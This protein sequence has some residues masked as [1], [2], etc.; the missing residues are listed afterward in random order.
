MTKSD[1]DGAEITLRGIM[2]TWPKIFGVML[3]L[4]IGAGT[5]VVWGGN[6][7]LSDRATQLQHLATLD[8]YVHMK[9]TQRDIFAAHV[10][11]KMDDVTTA[12]QKM[13]VK[14]DKINDKFDAHINQ[15]RTTAA[16]S[17]VP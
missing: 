17:V 5:V 10:S 9:G 3:S 16:L 14:L 7:V 2:I 15:A 1:H 13:D 12:L 8:E 6:I 4:L 11:D